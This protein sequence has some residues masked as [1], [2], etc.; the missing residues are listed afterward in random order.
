M[1]QKTEAHRKTACDIYGEIRPLVFL[2]FPY[3]LVIPLVKLL[4]F[5][6]VPLSPPCGALGAFDRVLSRFRT[7]HILCQISRAN[8]SLLSNQ[9][10][11]ISLQIE[12]FMEARSQPEASPLLE[13]RTR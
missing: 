2:I 11:V 7:L 8:L 13:N 5:L 9:K 6:A 10:S 3:E 4:T 1:V 12:S